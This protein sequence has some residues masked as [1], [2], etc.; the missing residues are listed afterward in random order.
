MQCGFFARRQS[1]KSFI[2]W[3]Q[4]VNEYETGK[5]VPNQ[6]GSFAGIGLSTQPF[7]G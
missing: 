7:K 3:H 5:A 2:I 1:K 6:V 4:V